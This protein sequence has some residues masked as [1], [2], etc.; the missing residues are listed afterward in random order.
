MGSLVM[1]S[2]WAVFVADAVWPAFRRG[3]L[4]F[5]VFLLTMTV[6]EIPLV[7]LLV[8]LV[9]LA[10]QTAPPG[11]AVSWALGLLSTGV[12]AGLVWLQVRARY[13]GTFLGDALTN[14]LGLGWRADLGDDL[15]TGSLWRDGI[16]RPFQRRSRGVEQIRGV[17]YGPDPRFHR[18][19]VYRPRPS[20]GPHPVLIQLHGGGFTQGGRSREGVAML[21]RLAAR[22]WLCLSVD[23]QLGEA[24]EFPNPLV[25]TKRAI[26]WIRD[27][28]DEYAADAAQV[29][30]LGQ[31]A[32][33]HLAI[34]AALTAGDPRF[35][36]GF[37]S[38]DTEVS[39]AVSLYGYLG[40][41]TAD[42]TSSPASLA[43]EDAPPMLIVH[44][45]LDTMVPPGSARTVASVL[46]TSSRSPVVYAEIPGMQ[47]DHDFFGSVR[48][49]LIA[50]EVEAFLD[51][52][53]SRPA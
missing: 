34:S 38:A 23:Y 16:L 11:G 31:S 29:Y 40:P 27:H 33:G 6:N 14:E 52:A 9:S 13:A 28:A 48:A 50:Q 10:S 53:R 18:L 20:V 7:L 26:A 8:F 1:V 21:L 43:R 15:P 42:P 12:A 2:I 49:R 45:E 19:D 35:Q 41:R 22:G 17:L 5:V 36:P 44:G 39:G 47:H 4:G 30:V 25:D 37:E 46:R 24:A 32:G 51:W 3:R